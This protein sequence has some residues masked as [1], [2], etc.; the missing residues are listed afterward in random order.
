MLFIETMPVLLNTGRES[1]VSSYFLRH[2]RFHSFCLYL[3]NMVVIV[4]IMRG[5]KTFIFFFFLGKIDIL[6]MYLLCN[7]NRDKY[8]YMYK[9]RFCI[10]FFFFFIY[11]LMDSTLLTRNI[12]YY[13][14]YSKIYNTYMTYMYK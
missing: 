7:M 14:R 4:V 13:S 9:K 11:I 12:K 3:Y 8:S 2:T 6:T 1:I 10:V 5:K